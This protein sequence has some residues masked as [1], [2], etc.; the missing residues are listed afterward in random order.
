MALPSGTFNV[1]RSGRLQITFSGVWTETISGNDWSPGGV[2]ELWLRGV[3]NDGVDRKTVLLGFPNNSGTLE[4]DYTA[5]TSVTVAFQV[6][7]YVLG[8]ISS[9]QASKLL[10]RCR[11]FKR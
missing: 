10:I 7:S 6:V 4:F 2:R 5:N 1:P 11:L 9:V 3:A 8:G